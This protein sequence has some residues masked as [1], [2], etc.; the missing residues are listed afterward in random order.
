MLTCLNVL[1]SWIVVIFKTRCWLSALSA[2]QSRTLSCVRAKAGP[3]WSSIRVYF[4]SSSEWGTPNI[5]KGGSWV[6]PP[7]SSLHV[8][9]QCGPS[10]EAHLGSRAQSLTVLAC[11]SGMIPAS[12]AVWLVCA[13][14][15]GSAHVRGSGKRLAVIFTKSQED[16]FERGNSSQAVVAVMTHD[17][18]TSHIAGLKSLFLQSSTFL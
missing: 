14:S 16:Y 6:S 7:T 13:P 8:S 1:L 9:A 10:F 4:S 18:L 15:K 12:V 2:D 11:L 17:I 5:M 3:C